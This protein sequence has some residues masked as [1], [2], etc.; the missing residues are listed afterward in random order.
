MEGFPR[1]HLDLVKRLYLRYLIHYFDEESWITAFVRYFNRHC[2]A[3]RTLTLQISRHTSIGIPE[4]LA[5]TEQMLDRHS[6]LAD[7]LSAIAPKERWTIA[8]SK[9]TRPGFHHFESLR[10]KLGRKE[11]W[12]RSETTTTSYY[13]LRPGRT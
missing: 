4:K 5:G 3:L 12:K 9:N 7:A 1:C 2:P 13:D 8:F 10:P 11:E 6:R